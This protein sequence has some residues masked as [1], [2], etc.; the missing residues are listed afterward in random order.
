M[1]RIARYGAWR[2]RYVRSLDDNSF[3]SLSVVISSFDTTIST[4]IVNKCVAATVIWPC[5]PSDGARSLIVEHDHV[6]KDFFSFMMGMGKKA[7]RGCLDASHDERSGGEIVCFPLS[8]KLFR[9]LLK[10]VS[11]YY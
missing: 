1:G 9:S 7:W 10:V 4:G 5:Q 8:I 3:A 6:K 2:R 11:V